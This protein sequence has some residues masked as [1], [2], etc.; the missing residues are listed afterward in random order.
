LVGPKK[1]DVGE[2]ESVIGTF[3]YN[4]RFPGQYY[5]AETGLNQNWNRDYDPVVGRYV[6]SDPIGLAG[7]SYSTYSYVKDDP[8]ALTDPRG[9]VVQRCCRRAR[10][11]LGLVPH[12]WLKTDTKVAGMN[13]TPACSLPGENQS[14]FLWIT[15]VVVSDASCETTGNCQTINDV[16][17]GCVNRELAIGKSLGRFG[18]TNNCVTFAWEVL[19]KCSKNPKVLTP[20]PR[21]E[22]R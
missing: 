19:T 7:G 20:P 6:E 10:I 5:D 2:C 3:A 16:D 13:D 8:I 14:D 1:T 21:F 17:E 12:C 22:G 18:F 9:L 4:L 15:P 11:A